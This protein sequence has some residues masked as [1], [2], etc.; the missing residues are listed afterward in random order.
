MTTLSVKNLDEKTFNY[1][2]LK[3]TPET[4]VT[5]LP[6]QLYLHLINSLYGELVLV[7]RI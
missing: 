4:Q 2:I 6:M 7:A 5:L 1:A 3:V